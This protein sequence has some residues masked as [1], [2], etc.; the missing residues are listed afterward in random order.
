MSNYFGTGADGTQTYTGIN[1]IDSIRDGDVVVKNYENLTINENSVLTTTNRCRG[2][3]IYVTGNCIVNGRLTMQRRGCTANPNDVTSTT[4][5]PNPPSDNNPVGS[6]GIV[7]ARLSN[8]YTESGKSEVNGCGLALVQAETKQSAL[9]GD[10]V[11]FQV[12]KEGALGGA[13]GKTNLAIHSGFPGNTSSKCTGGGAGGGAEYTCNKGAFSGSPGTSGTCFSGGTG[14]YTSFSIPITDVKTAIRYGG[15]GGYIISDVGWGGAGN[16]PSLESNSCKGGGG[17]GGFLALIVNGNIIIGP[18]GCIDSMGSDQLL[19][20]G[21]IN[22]P[23]YKDIPVTNVAFGG[24]GSGGGALCIMYGSS[25]TFNET[26][27]VISVSGGTG[28]TSR[29]MY[30]HEGN[31]TWY[32]AAGGQG[33]DGT[34]QIYKINPSDTKWIEGDSDCLVINS[35]EDVAIAKIGIRIPFENAYPSVCRFT[36]GV[37]GESS[38]LGWFDTRVKEQV[39]VLG[40]WVDF[41][42]YSGFLQKQYEYYTAGELPL[43]IIASTTGAEV[44]SYSKFEMSVFYDEVKYS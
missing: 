7:I 39:D 44:Y 2:L 27:S 31:R 10:G 5:T 25:I 3:V 6:N 18:N 29:F 36:V 24:G 37:S 32:P 23:A 35:A 40:E 41:H 13:G 28:G 1:Y 33:G 15:S 16:N 11:K 34:L 26:S 9:N 43:C 17:T 42:Y 14:G 4:F 12:Y 20:P 22:N 38:K 19:G 21:I 8:G 30:C